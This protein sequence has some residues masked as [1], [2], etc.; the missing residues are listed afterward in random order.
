MIYNVPQLHILTDP[1]GALSNQLTRTKRW[2]P[3]IQ[4]EAPPW[5][6]KRQPRD[7]KRRDQTHKEHSEHGRDHEGNA[8]GGAGDDLVLVAAGDGEAWAGEVREDVACIG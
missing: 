2:K 8:N 4:I 5:N 3:W 6:V 1:C 7:E